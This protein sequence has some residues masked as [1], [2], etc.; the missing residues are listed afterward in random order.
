MNTCSYCI[1][2]PQK[3]N[4]YLSLFVNSYSVLNTYSYCIGP[5]KNAYIYLYLSIELYL[6]LIIKL[7]ILHAPLFYLYT[8]PVATWKMVFN[9]R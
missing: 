7:N 1:K 6:N 4:L 8:Y 3:K 2:T 5:E 9:I